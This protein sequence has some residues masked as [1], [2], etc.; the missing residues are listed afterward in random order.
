MAETHPHLPEH[1][2]K[3]LWNSWDGD[4][5]DE[6]MDSYRRNHKTPEQVISDFVRCFAGDTPPSEAEKR[7]MLLVETKYRKEYGT[8]GGG[9]GC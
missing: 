1:A 8:G 9:G 2:R 3:S 7:L 6:Y 5:Q 4:E